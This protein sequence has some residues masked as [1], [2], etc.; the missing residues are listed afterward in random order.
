MVQV[1]QRGLPRPEVL[2]GLQEPAGAASVQGR[3]LEAAEALLQNELICLLH[4]EAS[5]YP[6]KKKGKR[7]RDAD[8]APALGP[9]APWEDIPVTPS[10]V[11]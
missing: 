9:L 3:P 10:S 1:I 4:H 2:T 11:G 7:K 5:K 8:D 6:F